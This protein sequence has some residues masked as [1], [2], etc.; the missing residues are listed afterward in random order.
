MGWKFTCQIYHF[1]SMQWKIKNKTFFHCR[2]L[3]VLRLV[4]FSRLMVNCQSEWMNE[5]CSLNSFCLICNF[6]A[7]Q[8]FKNIVRLEICQKIYMTGFSGQKFYTLKVHILQ[9]F[10]L[11]KKQCK[12]INLAAFLL[13]FNWVCKSLMVSV[14]N[15]T[16]CV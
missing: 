1:N 7:A 6:Y 16:W 4:F 8:V 12:C 15:H 5:L 10:L 2:I 9:L 3:F 13:E 11:K 14:Q